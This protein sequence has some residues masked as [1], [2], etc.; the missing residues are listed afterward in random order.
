MVISLDLWITHQLLIDLGLGQPGGEGL[1]LL[2]GLPFYITLQYHFLWK[3][4]Y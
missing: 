1:L 3:S 2:A 4:L